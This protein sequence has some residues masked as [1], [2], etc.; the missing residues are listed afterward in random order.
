MSSEIHAQGVSD[1]SNK[2]SVPKWFWVISIL[3]SVWFLMDMSA[4]IMRV[5]ML[6]ETLKGMPE[7]HQN[8]YL[9]MP[10]WVNIVFALEVFGGMIGSAGLL[11]RKKWALI[12]FVISLSGTLSQTGYIYFLSDAINT[13]GSMAVIMPL[14]GIT[15]CLVL[16]IVSKFSISKHW[17]G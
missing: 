13:M 15:I 10:S 14:V 3:A 8:L 17:I 7:A 6:D 5:F 12:G 1:A 2:A 11:L 4:F 9:N 16:I